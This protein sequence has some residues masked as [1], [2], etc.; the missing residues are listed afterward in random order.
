MSKKRGINVDYYEVWSYCKAKEKDGYKEG[1]CVVEGEKQCNICEYKPSNKQK[2]KC[3][4][5]F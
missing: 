5:S 1:K 3:N 4:F 2:N